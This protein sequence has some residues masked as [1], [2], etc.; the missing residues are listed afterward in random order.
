LKGLLSALLPHLL[1]AADLV[2]VEI[3]MAADTAAAVT[4]AMA[5]AAVAM[6]VRVHVVRLQI[7]QLP[8]QFLVLL[9]GLMRP[10]ALVLFNQTMAAKTSL[11]IFLS[12]AHLA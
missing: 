1:A 5:A 2:A 6:I 12:L 10:K 9:N 3:E 7:P 11:F 8:Y 4:A